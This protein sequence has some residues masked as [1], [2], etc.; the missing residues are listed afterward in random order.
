VGPIE[1]DLSVTISWVL[2]CDCMDAVRVMRHNAYDL[3]NRRD[4][5]IPD[6]GICIWRHH[7]EFTPFSIIIPRQNRSLSYS[8]TSIEGH[9]HQ[10][11]RNTLWKDWKHVDG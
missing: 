9:R 10:Y 11:H 1:G 7:K 2:C 8:S 6:L 3:C 4:T 5:L